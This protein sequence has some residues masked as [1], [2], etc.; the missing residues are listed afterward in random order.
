MD[1]LP[2]A[3]TR[4]LVLKEAVAVRKNGGEMRNSKM[5]PEKAMEIEIRML[6][7]MAARYGGLIERDRE[8]R[9]AAA[10]R[11]RAAY[12]CPEMG[13]RGKT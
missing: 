11:A 9:R 13:E 5:A 7:E 3:P 1:E 6:K 12:A 2:A 10:R 4:K 8:K